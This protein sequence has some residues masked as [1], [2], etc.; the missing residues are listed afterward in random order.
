MVCKSLIFS[1][2]KGVKLGVP[3]S[4]KEEI[5]SF[6]NAFFLQN[7]FFQIFCL[8]FKLLFLTYFKN[9]KVSPKFALFFLE[10]FFFLEKIVAFLTYFF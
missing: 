7:I 5:N 3:E 9:E 1:F 10:N 6:K 8:F 4:H 2:D